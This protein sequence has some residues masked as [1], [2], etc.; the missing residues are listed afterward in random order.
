MVELEYTSSLSLDA[1]RIE[2]SNLSAPTIYGP[3]VRKDGR[4]HVVLVYSDGFKTSRSWPRYLLE[5]KLG[6]DLEDWETVDHIDGDKSNDSPDNLQ[7]LSRPDNS[8][9]SAFSVIGLHK[10]KWCG[11]DFQ[12]S[13]SQ[14]SK[15]ELK[16]LNRFCSKSCSGFYGKSIQ[17]GGE[18]LHTESITINY[19]NE[20]GQKT[21]RVIE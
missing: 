15:R 12:L 19:Q 1:E 17:M 18:Y 14:R 3:Y 2:S 9:K 10:C 20:I 13:V 16:T 21:V 11:S 5:T 6:R 7:A 4:K 8:R